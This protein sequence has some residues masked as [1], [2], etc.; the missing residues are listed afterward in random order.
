MA[1]QVLVPHEPVNWAE[2]LVALRL[3]LRP[4][5][6]AVADLC[7]V[8]SVQHRLLRRALVVPPA[9]PAAELRALRLAKFA[10][11]ESPPYIQRSLAAWPGESWRA[12]WDIDA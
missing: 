9:D 4:L 10:L 1:S 11:D 3:Q 2:E 7:G 12:G 8:E 6:P 5:L